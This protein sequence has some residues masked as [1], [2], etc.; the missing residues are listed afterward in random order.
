MEAL[1]ADGWEPPPWLTADRPVPKKSPDAPSKPSTP[2]G[3]GAAPDAIT[4]LWTLPLD[5]P[6]P[7]AFQIQFGRRVRGGWNDPSPEVWNTPS[8]GAS[9]LYMRTLFNLPRQA[10][11]K[12]KKS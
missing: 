6:L 5:A 4:C 1:K 8:F 12:R 11:D 9:F 3:G 10:R 2:P 7:L